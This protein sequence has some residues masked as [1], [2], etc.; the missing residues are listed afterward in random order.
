MHL[1]K[2]FYQYLIQKGSFATSILQLS[3]EMFKNFLIDS[4]RLF[5]IP[6]VKFLSP[7]N[8]ISLTEN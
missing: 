1:E 8:I 4:I 3:S 5:L 2:P 6:S 7:T